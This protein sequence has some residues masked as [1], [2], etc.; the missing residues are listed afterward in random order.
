MAPP[1]LGIASCRRSLQASGSLVLLLQARKQ[2]VSAGAALPTHA[3]GRH[4]S[5]RAHPA[6]SQQPVGRIHEEVSVRSSLEKTSTDRPTPKMAVAMTLQR[7]STPAT[8][9]RDPQIPRQHSVPEN[10]REAAVRLMS[11][12]RCRSKSPDGVAYSPVLGDRGEKL[13]T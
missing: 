3:K 2:R 8:R 7:P 10:L 6:P 5:R 13:E 4:P 12:R 11:P 9:G 1:V